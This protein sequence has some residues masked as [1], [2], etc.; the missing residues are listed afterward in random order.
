[1]L[2]LSWFTGCFRNEIPGGQSPL[3][4][5]SPR[6]Y[7]GALNK[8]HDR[9]ND[10]RRDRPND[11]AEALYHLTRQ[12]VRFVEAMQSTDNTAILNRIA[13]METKIMATQA[14]LAADLRAV[15]TQQEKTAAEIAEV[16]A[17]QTVSLDKIKELE[18]LVASGGTVT[19]EL[20]DAVDSVKTQAQ[21]VDDLIPDVPTPPP[22]EEA[23]R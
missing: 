14:E 21:V 10:E 5:A 13:E 17:A 23:R 12:L 6:L 15:R 20:I 7:L 8:D 18:V 16:Q 1:M 3:D 2:V 19:Q 22:V 9:D 4:K 11:L